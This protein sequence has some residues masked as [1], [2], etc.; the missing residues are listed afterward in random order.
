MKFYIE[1]Q[2]D[3]FEGKDD[4]A[5][6]KYL[7]AVKLLE[8]DRR[9]LGDTAGSGSFL[10]DRIE[11][12]YL[13]AL[14]HLDHKQYPQAFELLERSRARAMAELLASRNLS[15]RAPELQDL[16]SQSVDLR[17]QIGKAQNNLFDASAS[18]AADTGEVKDLQTKVERAGSAGPCPSGKNPATRAETG[19]EFSEKPPVSLQS[20]QAA[21]RQ[22]NYDLLYY[23]TLGSGTVIWHIGGDSVQVIKVYY[24]R[25]LLT[26]RVAAL[27][28]SLTDANATFDESVATELFTEPGEPGAPV[29]SYTASGDRAA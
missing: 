14:Q 1:G 21:A 18:K 12:Y 19:E 7:R 11:I 9:K 8:S 5:L 25:P 4:E 20:A 6:Q 23:L 10:S 22:G 27:R 16:F 13:A 17:A 26:N 28:K 29:H 3:E 2:L 15:F 24:T